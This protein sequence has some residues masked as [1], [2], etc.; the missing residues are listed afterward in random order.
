MDN[1]DH[2]DG[3]AETLPAEERHGQEA[4]PLH[5]VLEAKEVRALLARKADAMSTLAG[6]IAT[7]LERKDLSALELALGDRPHILEAADAKERIAGFLDF[8][9]TESETLTFASTHVPEGRFAIDLHTLQWLRSTNEHKHAVLG[10]AFV[11]PPAPLMVGGR[12]G[13][14]LNR[15]RRLAHLFA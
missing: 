14:S 1:N 6:Q 2:R 8:L 10:D 5:Y 12:N 3:F 11:G 4:K 7:A 13:D 9:R 15:Q